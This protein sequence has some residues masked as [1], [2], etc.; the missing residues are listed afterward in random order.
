MAPRK[1]Q[2]E[3]INIDNSVEVGVDQAPIAVIEKKTSQS[4]PSVPL[5]QVQAMI[6][7]AIAKSK[8]PQV[9]KRKHVTEHTAHVWRFDGK[10]VVDFV[11][12]N[13]DEYK[14][15]KVHAFQKFNEQK[16][17]Y[18]TWI[19]LKFHDGSTKEVPLTTYVDNRI[20][21]RCPI[22]KRHQKDMSYSQG[23]VE[24]KKEVGDKLVGTG[25]L[26]DQTV[27]AYEET[28]EIKTPEGDVYMIPAHAI[29]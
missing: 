25:V 4:E 21:V 5:S 23:E 18:E 6:D 27:E 2:V 28:F 17:A 11:D 10:W 15:G 24:K 16:R 22:I 13:T 3:E 26:V 12:K 20:M 1:Q 9:I 14:K 8:N 29:A 19:D 7:E